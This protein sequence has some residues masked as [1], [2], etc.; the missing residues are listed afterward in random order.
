MFQISET[1]DRAMAAHNL[2]SDYKL[3]LVMGIDSKSLSNY[4]HNKTLP[5]VRVLSKLCLLT[6][7]D[8]ALLT[9]QVEYARAKDD[10]TRSIW[11]DIAERLKLTTK[12]AQA[13]F[14]SVASMV[15]IMLVAGLL[16][17]AQTANVQATS[18]KAYEAGKGVLS[19]YY[20]K[21][22]NVFKAVHRWLA[23][24]FGQLLRVHDHA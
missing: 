22:C 15:S 14:A 9:A 6:G 4:R 21:L 12:T 16:V 24:M 1:L 7:D 2:P 19:L 3:A 18:S 5:D 13:G 11:A 23:G 17:L 8:P 10:E 20:V